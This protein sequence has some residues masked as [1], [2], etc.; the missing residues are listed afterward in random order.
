MHIVNWYLQDSTG[1]YISGKI[2]IE[3]LKIEK[4]IGV[5]IPDVDVNK[6]ENK[7]KNSEFQL[8]NLDI[9]LVGHV[10]NIT[11]FGRVFLQFSTP[12]V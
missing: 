4:F 1:K 7:T 9:E 12:I 11:K 6:T 5:V 3:I 2:K 10:K 8:N